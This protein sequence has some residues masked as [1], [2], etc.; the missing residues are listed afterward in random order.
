MGILPEARVVQ[1]EL[2]LRPGETL[3]V[4]TDGVTEAMDAHQTLFGEERLRAAGA[5]VA[6]DSAQG[7]IERVLAH[8]AGV[9]RDAAVDERG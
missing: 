3:L 1:R 8:V 7:C 5:D 9:E 2:V 4:Y 6:G